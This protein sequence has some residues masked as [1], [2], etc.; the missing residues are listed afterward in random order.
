MS[1]VENKYQECAHVAGN[2]IMGNLTDQHISANTVNIFVSQNHSTSQPQAKPLIKS[3]PEPGKSQAIL[4]A[5]GNLSDDIYILISPDQEIIYG[6]PT[7][8]SSI[9][10]ESDTQSDKI[11]S[12]KHLF[13]A[14]SP[15]LHNL[16]SAQKKI[17]QTFRFKSWRTFSITHK[18]NRHQYQCT[19]L[20]IL[21]KRSFTGVLIHCR[22][23]FR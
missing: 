20:P 22:P 14:C 15:H 8:W 3:L 5:I 21:V 13:R 2:M 10:C 6:S 1:F 17:E 16:R 4:T 18:R 7:F 9:G 23:E 19:S 11:T 12:S